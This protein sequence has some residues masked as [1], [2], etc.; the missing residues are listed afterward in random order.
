MVVIYQIT[1]MGMG[2][3]NDSVAYLRGARNILDGEGYTRFVGDGTLDPITHFPPMFSFAM[4]SLGVFGLDVIR[5]ARVINI[6]CFGLNVFLIGLIVYRMSGKSW[7]GI[8]GA[9]FFMISEPLLRIHTFALS[10]PLYLSIMC[11]ALL[12]LTWQIERPRW[13]YVAAVGVLTSFAYLTRYVGV[14]M[15]ATG[16]AVFL[17]LQPTWRRRFLDI[18]IFLATSLPALAV[19]SLRNVRVSGNATNRP[20]YWHPLSADK[21]NEGLGNFWGWL[22]PEV[23]GLIEERFWFWGIV[24]AALLSALAV[25][26][27]VT[28]IRYLKGKVGSENRLL[29][30]ALIVASHG[31]AYISGLIIAMTF[32]DDKTIFEQ[33]MLAP[34]TVSLLIMI[35]ALLIWLW[36]RPQKSA[37]SAVIVIGLLLLVSCLEDTV[38][39][40]RVLSTSGQGYAS[41]RWRNS[42]TVAAVKDIPDDVIIFSNKITA[43]DI[44]ADRPAFLIPWRYEPEGMP[45]PTYEQG[46]ADYRQQLFDRK[47]VFVIFNYEEEVRLGNERVIDLTYGMPVWREFSD[48]IIFGI[49]P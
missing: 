37:R 25:W 8:A 21:W 22:L 44:L 47:A 40:V 48:G 18:G 29:V 1:P 35:M 45:D 13:Y 39:T 30:M 43:M 32:F 12:L 33:R 23:G 46:V 31:L 38:D 26:V 3:V 49:L 16:L 2:M 36:Q 27:I 28:T 11:T 42:E 10:E 14:A 5:A 17:F 34:F 24:I 20:V 19:W 9:A 6:L 4:V 15:Y 7:F 41:G